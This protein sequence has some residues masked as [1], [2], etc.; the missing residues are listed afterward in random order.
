MRL[1]VIKIKK[2]EALLLQRLVVHQSAVIDLPSGEEL[3]RPSHRHGI[4]VL[5]E[6]A[7]RAQTCTSGRLVPRL[8]S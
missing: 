3:L 6:E 8:E 4:F 7:G 2:T 1:Q 5:F